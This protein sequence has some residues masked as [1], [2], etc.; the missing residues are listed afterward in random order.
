MIWF[1]KIYPY[2]SDW[3]EKIPVIP[4]KIITWILIIFMVCN[5][6]VSSAALVRYDQRGNGVKAENRVEQW[7]DTHF[8]D[9]RMKKIYPKAKAV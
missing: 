4:G 6:V 8:D 2:L 7:L 9:T 1:K 5:I 3:I